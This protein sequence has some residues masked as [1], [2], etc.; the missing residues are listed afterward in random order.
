MADQPFIIKFIASKK[1][2]YIL[3]VMHTLA[4]VA[5]WLAEV[6]LLMQILLSALL[7]FSAGYY[8]QT[9][10]SQTERQLLFQPDTGWQLNLQPIQIKQSFISRP[11]LIINYRQAAK[12][13][14]L[15]LLADSADVKALR[16]LRILLRQN[17]SGKLM[18]NDRQ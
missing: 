11:L 12:S 17:A 16:Q 5:V 7:L 1:L 9:L 3:L 18:I 13:A 14:A 10:F 6:A 4:L 8:W 15:V 2:G